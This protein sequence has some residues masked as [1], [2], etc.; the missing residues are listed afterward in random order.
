MG[1]H[2]DLTMGWVYSVAFSPDGASVLA[3][4]DHTQVELWDAGTGVLL[5]SFEGHARGV[6]SV[7]FSPDG[8]RVLSGG[9]DNTL[10]LWDIA[11]GALLHTFEGH[12][13]SVTSVAFSPSRWC[14][15]ALRELGPKI[16]TMGRCHRRAVPHL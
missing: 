1:G 15:R 12:A 3:G 2:D 8:E 11:T 16:E 10:K 4:S 7:A 14:A 6:S 13:G 9:N 5:H